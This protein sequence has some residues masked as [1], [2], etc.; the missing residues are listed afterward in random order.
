M[1]KSIALA[2]VLGFVGFS[3]SAQGYQ[4]TLQGVRVNAQVGQATCQCSQP[5]AVGAFCPFDNQ[6]GTATHTRG[7]PPGVQSRQPDRR[8]E[9]P[10]VA[11]P[12][13][14]VI[15]RRDLARSGVIQGQPEDRR[16]VGAPHGA[17]HAAPPVQVA[18]APAPVS[19]GGGVGRVFTPGVSP[20]VLADAFKT[21]SKSDVLNAPVEDVTAAITATSGVTVTAQKIFESALTECAVALVKGKRRVGVYARTKASGEKVYSFAPVGPILYECTGQKLYVVDG[22]VIG[23]NSGHL[24]APKSYTED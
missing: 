16:P 20:A 12:N 10:H 9:T 6:P 24:Y 14:V 15:D 21:G 23:D 11:D 18:Q 3:A 7:T 5:V 8:A 19:T 13:M 17:P 4:C 1:I 2:T 22:V